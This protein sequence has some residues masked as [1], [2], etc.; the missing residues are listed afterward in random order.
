MDDGFGGHVAVTYISSN[1]YGVTRVNYKGEPD[2]IEVPQAGGASSDY[3]TMIAWVPAP[4]NYY[5]IFNNTGT[6]RKYITSPDLVNWS[7]V[8][9]TNSVFPSSGIINIFSTPE[10]SSRLFGW[11][12]SNRWYS[13]D[14][15]ANWTQDNSIFPDTPTFGNNRSKNP[16]PLWM[17]QY[18]KYFAFSRFNRLMSTS[19]GVT[20]S[21]EFS[22]KLATLN[23]SCT[24]V[25]DQFRDR[26]VYYNDNDGALLAVDRYTPSK[27]VSGVCSSN[28][29]NTT[30][31][32]SDTT[33]TWST[34]GQIRDWEDW[35][36]GFVV[37]TT[38]P[39]GN[40]AI[41]CGGMPQNSTLQ[42]EPPESQEKTAHLTVDSNMNVI[43]YSSTPTPALINRESSN[44]IQFPDLIAGTSPDYQIPPGSTLNVDVVAYNA[45]GTSETLTDSVTP[46]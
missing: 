5:I 10:L 34:G 27:I 36:T 3:W 39:S 40:V 41:T 16:F 20:W 44:T 6:S 12:T 30:A 33:G 15:G 29:N 25:Y 7:E 21:L 9:T 2:I 1:K 31:T 14:G 28:V 18:Q 17:P 45:A 35:K 19:D 46:T 43:G 24:P 38:P 11:D 32:F 26:F 37:T 22:D 4:Y 8:Q 23:D 42:A 13:D